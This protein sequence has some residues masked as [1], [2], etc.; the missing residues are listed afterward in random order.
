MCI[1]HSPDRFPC[2]RVRQNAGIRGK[3]RVLANT[4]TTFNS[5]P[6]LTVIANARHYLS[7]SVLASSSFGALLLKACSKMRSI[8]LPIR[9]SGASF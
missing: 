2:S 6:T 4:A 3:S 1:A 8:C 9:D 7:L 5:R